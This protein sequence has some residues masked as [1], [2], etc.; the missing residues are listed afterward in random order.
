MNCSSKNLT[1][2][3]KNF[4]FEM[5]AIR[6]KYA[7]KNSVQIKLDDEVRDIDTIFRFIKPLKIDDF[8]KNRTKQLKENLELKKAK[9]K[10]FKIENVKNIYFQTDQNIIKILYLKEK[11]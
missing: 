8:Y 11:R 7:H 3:Y 2:G 5:T 1:M 4:C 9:S 6:N 10:I